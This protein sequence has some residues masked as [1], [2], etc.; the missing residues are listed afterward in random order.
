MRNI[1]LLFVVLLLTARP[2][3]TQDNSATAP[4]AENSP[5]QQLAIRLNQLII[6]IK[7][8]QDADPQQQKIKRRNRISPT[9]LE[10]LIG[11]ALTA[12]ADQETAAVLSR[13][14][15]AKQIE[16]ARTDKQVS[17]TSSTAGSTSLV[18]KGTVPAILGF[19]VENG[20]A[21]ETQTGTILTFR[22]NPVGV[23]QLLAKKGY[24]KSYDA[25]QNDTATKYLS[26]LSVA[27]SFDTA[28]GVASSSATM[29]AAFTGSEQ[30]LSSVTAHYDIINKR[31]PRDRYFTGQWQRLT[32]TSLSKI[33]KDMDPIL[34][35]FLQNGPLRLWAQNFQNEIGD[36]QDADIESIVTTEFQ[37]LGT[38]SLPAALDNSIKTLNTDYG[39]FLNSRAELLNMIARGPLLSVEY[40]NNFA[41]P[42][43]MLP[44][45]STF[46]VAGE[47][48]LFAG[49]ADWTA[50]FNAEVYNSQ[51]AAITRR[52]KSVSF[53]SELDVP[54]TDPRKVGNFVL[55]GAYKYRNLTADSLDS[56]GAVLIP[57]GVMSVG[58]IKLSI[59]VKNAGIK[60]PIS[61]TFANRSEFIKEKDIRGNVGITL[62]MD[63]LFAG[64]SNAH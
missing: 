62:D 2:A 27:V 7:A 50:N 32:M 37:K 30:Q 10:D 4:P 56:S 57:K 58:Q 36:A 33:P 45:V 63:S 1:G 31:D 47:T 3:A 12:R 44:D 48:G 16:E 5:G 55:S 11:L 40:T 43:T 34:G 29:P 9:R 24:L 53:S 51:T 14:E 52:L 8:E 64:L 46:T 6:D 42:G 49:Q 21:T 60:I 26:H 59:P 35:Q 13:G 22:A 18:N 20:A 39:A 61:V 15:F 38:I 23:I 25:I 28:R 54:L 19:A 41:A 17:S